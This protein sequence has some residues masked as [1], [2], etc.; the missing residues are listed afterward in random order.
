[1]LTRKRTIP[2]SASSHVDDKVLVGLVPRKLDDND[3]PFS[4]FD[5]APTLLL[6]QLIHTMLDKRCSIMLLESDLDFHVVDKYNQPV[7]AS[8]KIFVIFPMGIITIQHI[9]TSDLR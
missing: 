4:D 1:M 3:L 5:T 6:T 2:D 8:L 7:A 9:N